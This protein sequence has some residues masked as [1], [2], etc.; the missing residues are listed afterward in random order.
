MAL[1]DKIR[2]LSWFDTIDK[3][4]DVLLE[5]L[6]N[7]ENIWSRVKDLE[8]SSDLPIYADNAAAT[9]GGVGVG[10]QYRTS[11]GVLMVRF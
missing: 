2:K 8:N 6:E 10:K 11:T 4:K 7:I 9:A 1:Q 5:T 3:L